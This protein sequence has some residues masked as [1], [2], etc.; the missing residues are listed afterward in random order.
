MIW[1]TQLLIEQGHEINMVA[2]GDRQLELRVSGEEV[3]DVVDDSDVIVFQ[4][5]THRFLA[6]AVPILRAKGTAVVVDI[7]DDLSSIHPSNPAYEAMHPR[8]EMRRDPGK[9]EPRRHSWAHLATACREASLVTVSTP[10]LL[11]RYAS[12]GRGRVL[13]NYLPDG[14]YNT[15]HTDSDVIGWP[16]ALVSHPD[17]PTAVGGALARLDQDGATFR[18]VGDPTGCGRAFGLREDPPGARDVDV[19]GWPGKVAELGIGIAPLADTRFNRC[20]CVDS[21]MRICTHRGIIEASE[22]VPGDRVWRDG[23]KNVEAVEHDVPTPG[24]EITTEGG[25]QLRLTPDHR[26]LVNGEWMY[27]KNIVVGDRMSMEPEPVGVVDAV[28]APWPADSRMGSRGAT[29]SDPVAYLTAPDGPR[30]DLTPRWGR[31]LGAFVGDGCA[32]QAT[33]LTISCDGQDQDWIDI[34]MDDFRAFGFNPITQGRKTFS[35]EIIRRRDVR[36]ASAHLLRVLNG[37]GLTEIRDNGRPLRKVCVPEIIWRSPREVIAEFL[38]GYFEADGTCTSSGVQVVSKDEHLIRDIQRLLLLFGIVSKVRARTTTAQNGFR[39]T[40]WT[41]NLGRDAADTFAKEIGFRSER[42]RARLTEIT[43]RPHSNAY[44]PMDWSPKVIEVKPCM[45]TPVDIQ[46]EGS[47]YIAA[48]FVSHNSWLK[49]LEMSA[50]GVPWVAS[51]RA[52]YAR[53]NARGAGILAERGRVWYRELSRLRESADLRAEV[54]G[55]GREAAEGLRLR[56]HFGEWIDAWTFAR[57]IESRRH[58]V[59]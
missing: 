53:L 44:R 6:Q 58:L 45:V 26:M 47:E 37:W 19:L 4:R 36:I 1:A 35:G 54:A 41:V 18:V 9:R 16:A 8:N 12:H 40:A 3:L 48:G 10:G 2:P 15:P 23:W 30:V 29:P 33:Q 14:Y 50:L 43:S 38:A 22:I 21:S 17:D 11:E 7:D 24:F 52:E 57:E 25:Y 31:F 49:P 20:K 51:P 28:R 59:A 46:V 32:G 34:L 13:P 5:V 27:A 56:D 39:G 55:R 42:K